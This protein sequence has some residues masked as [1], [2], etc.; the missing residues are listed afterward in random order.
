[1]FSTTD[2]TLSLRITARSRAG[3]SQKYFHGPEGDLDFAISLAG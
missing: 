3:I 1:M 2:R